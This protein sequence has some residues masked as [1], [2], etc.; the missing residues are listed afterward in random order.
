[1]KPHNLDDD[2]CQAQSETTVALQMLRIAFDD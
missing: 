2:S 1:M